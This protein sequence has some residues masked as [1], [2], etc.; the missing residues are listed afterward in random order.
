MSVRNSFG[1]SF[2]LAAIALAMTT[3][4][5]EAQA[6]QLPPAQ[7][8]ADRYVQAIGG[9]AALARH[10]H[11][12]VVSEMTL[13]A[14]G[15]TMSADLFTSSPNKMLLKMEAAGMGAMSSGYD[16][17]VAWSSNSMQGPRVLDGA[18]LKEAIRQ[19]DFESGLDYAKSYRMET[20][21]ELTVGGRPCWNV[22]MTHIAS[23]LDLHNCFDKENALLVR[24][25]MKSQSAMGEMQVDVTMSEYKDFDGIKM[26]TRSVTS[27]NGQEMTSVIKS[28]SH[29][30]IEPSVYALPADVRALRPQN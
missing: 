2:T 11:R 4:G 28:V 8:I 12:R 27:M 13:P 24:T 25:S 18:E 1:R 5:A 30:P 6:Q 15:M 19:A 23:G 16:G 17:T 14:M 10:K 29:A 22:K 7:Q 26:A 9:R 21:G 3:A 20:V